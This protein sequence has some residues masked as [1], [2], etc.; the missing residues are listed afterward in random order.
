M[1][2]WSTPFSREHAKMGNPCHLEGIR[3]A[4]RMGPVQQS[5][6][7]GR[8]PIAAYV[9][10]QMLSS[11]NWACKQFLNK[12]GDSDWFRLHTVQQIIEPE[13]RRRNPGDAAPATPGS[14]GMHPPPLGS[15]PLLQSL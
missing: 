13:G 3:I 8:S 11:R 5:P 7:N 10:D 12:A 14:Y 6:A 1:V 9:A 2:W 15:M 4:D